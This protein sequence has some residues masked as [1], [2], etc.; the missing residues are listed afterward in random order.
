VDV[1]AN[2]RQLRT[3]HKQLTALAA[4][5]EQDF[6]A[7]GRHLKDKKLPPEILARHQAAVNEF[8]LRQSEFD[9]L[10]ATVGS[11]YD[12]QQGQSLQTAINDL[13]RF[14]AAHPNQ[15]THTPSDPNKLPFGTSSSKVRAPIESERAFKTSLF[16]P[17][18]LL[19]MLAGPI[20]NGF[21]LPATTLPATPTPEDLAATEDIVLTPAIKAQAAALNNN[22]VQIYNWVRNNIEF[23]PTY[24]SIQGADMTLQTKRGNSFDTASLLI[25]LLRAAGVPARYVYGTIQVPADQAMNWVGGVTKPEAAQQLM[26]QGGIPNIGMASGGA[27]KFIKLEH[28]W[29]EAYVDYVPSRGAVN[30]TPDSWI[31]MDASYKQYTYTQGMDLKTAVPLDAQAF[32]NQA[33]TG[34]TVDPSGWVQNVNGAAIQSALTSYQ[35]QVQDYINTT[36]PN[37]TVGD[38]IGSKTIV[39]ENYSILMGTLPYTTIATGGKFTA[40][41]DSLKWKIKLNLY[42]STLDRALQT[43]Q[44]SI[45]LALSTIGTKRLSASYVPSTAA[46]AQVINSYK[47]AAKLPLYLVNET[48]EMHLDDQILAVSQPQRMGA[49]Q[50]WTYTLTRPGSSQLEENFKLDSAVGA[51]VVFGINGAGVSFEQIASRY[52]TT[53]PNSSLENLH[54]LSLGYWARAEASDA[55][56]AKQY[57]AVS[58]RL[59]S[60]GMFTQPVSV[61]YSWG[62]PLLGSYKSY[63]IDIVKLALSGTSV[64]GRF[65]TDYMIQAGVTNSF[66][67]GR[68]FEEIFDYASGNGFSAVAVIAKAVANGVPLWRITT[69]N[70]QLFFGHSILSAGVKQE[71]ADAVNAGLVVF[72]PEE[73][74]DVGFWA[75]QGYIAVDPITGSGMYIVNNANGGDFAACEEASQPL[76]QSLSQKILTYMAI[77][78]AALIVAGVIARSGGSA[79]PVIVTAMR[80]V[81]ITALT[82]S[83]TSYAAGSCPSNEKCHRGSI[84]AQGRDIAGPGQGNS[85]TK[86]AP[87][88]QPTPLTLAQGLQKITELKAILTPAELAIREAY[89]VRAETYMKNAAATGGVCAGPPRSFGPDP[90]IKDHVSK[91]V[92]VDINVNAG[93]AFVP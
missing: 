64:D 14:M 53:D 37:A 47:S 65:P 90:T 89:F 87:W 85:R 34:A 17:D 68:I 82:W 91:G 41:P 77:A 35:T 61:V 67:E 5:A 3:K 8:H 81:G 28:V 88:A 52:G 1:A 71:I 56:L 12:K 4:Q 26:G 29:V 46:D 45:E 2:I 63:S 7:T 75:G 25:G 59:P 49:D 6:A 20:P 24:G 13:A 62:I 58:Y 43:T 70:L 86:S 93:Q 39:P 84:Q 66:L 60:V 10:M 80:I 83:S 38:V 92:R 31:P 22:P 40:V 32:V 15:Q 42:G 79:A 36:K 48:L 55:M 18:P 69:E 16:R 51:Q 19:S 30:K 54:H 21:T 33:Q 11:A 44:M 50:F 78:A 72:A 73:G 27:I 76:T 57:G 23:L 74:V 9:R